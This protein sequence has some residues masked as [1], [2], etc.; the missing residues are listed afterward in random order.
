MLHNV[1]SAS[2]VVMPYALIYCLPVLQKVRSDVALALASWLS[3]LH[4]VSHMHQW[5]YNVCGL[6]YDKNRSGALEFEELHAVLADLG[7]MVSPFHCIP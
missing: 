6:Q 1:Y 4:F 2:S 7:I 3:S 5:I